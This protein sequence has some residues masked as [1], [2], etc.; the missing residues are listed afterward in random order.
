MKNILA[1]RNRILA[2]ALLTLLITSLVMAQEIPQTDRRATELRHLDL[3]YDA[4][5][6]KTKEEWQARAEFLRKQ[7]LFAAGLLPM[8]EKT[9]LNAKIFGKTDKGDYTVEKVYF[10]S[11]PGHYVTG[12]LYRP[13]KTTAQ[14]AGEKYPAVLLPHGHWAF[15]RLENQP[16]NSGPA[17]A[18]N[19][20][21]QGYVAFVWDMVG[22]N[23]SNVVP[24]TFA[25]HREGLVRES[26]WGINLLGL[27]LWNSIRA[28]DF[29]LSLPDVDAERLGVTG[30]SGGGTQTFLL[31]AV[32]NRIK[33][34]APVN[35]ISSIM[36]GG[37]VC[38]NAPLL[39]IDTNNME[40]GAM[41]APRPLMMIAATGD[42]TKNTPTVEFP[43]LQ[44]IYKL[45][46]A[47]D[48]IKSAQ[49]DSPHNYHKESREAV[50]GW[51]AHWLQG[52][53]EV[54]PIKEK[55][56]SIPTLTE[57]LVFY[58]IPR[59][60]N[61]L[62]ENQLTES[63]IEARKK[64]FQAALP[65]DAASLEKFRK[66][67]GTALKYSLMAEY[68]RSEDLVSM[69]RNPPGI[70]MISRRNKG[71]LISLKIVKSTAKKKLDSYVLL[72]SPDSEY[73]SGA[74]ELID[75]LLKEGHNVAFLT[76]FPGRNIGEEADK[77]KFLT[78]YNRTDQANRM[79]D[80][81]TAIAY[82]N[83]NKGTAKLSVIGLKDA[84][85]Y[86]LLAR[87]L[88][89][90]I[91]RMIVDAA[92]FDNSGE[93]DFLQR[94]AIP[95]I[96]SA[97]DFTTAVALSALNS[98]LIHNTGER[99]KAAQL[100]ELYRRAGKEIDFKAQAGKLTEVEIVNWLSGK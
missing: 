35:M 5:S 18:A 50:Y 70:T 56:S 84:G 65:T 54:T 25:N 92:Q 67:Y 81:L 83:K 2:L 24:H 19:F 95:G 62:T 17:R 74:K 71:D 42:W 36:Q 91:D 39:R 72:A 53:A 87:G 47:A 1:V 32:D 14:T 9:P 75:Q 34:S 57:L 33:V 6:F 66:Q 41:M 99:F 27:Q 38:E 45:F 30:E 60:N 15:G 43:A 21:R 7:I 97:G 44:N 28:T 12:N 90:N 69:V 93:A 68:P 63:L 76:C 4:P 55:S 46:D 77:Y 3:T 82:L 98:L 31:Y 58:G 89:P 59:P 96:R 40:I 88:A 78:T 37:S 10:E 29:I 73:T 100:S 61:E 22:Y 26:L 79:Q 86:A 48:K 8:P 23:D 13:K 11:V 52:R 80:I 64:Q 20:A 85:L 16:L 94:L 51:F 49:F